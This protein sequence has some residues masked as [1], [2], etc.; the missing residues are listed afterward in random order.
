MTTDTEN[1][2]LIKRLEMEGQETDAVGRLCLEARDALEA[3][4]RERDTLWDALSWIDTFDPEI[5]AAVRVN[6]GL[7]VD[8]RRHATGQRQGG[9]DGE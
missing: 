2:D 3:A 9:D 1:A 8:A 7:D 6:Y 5:T 4:E